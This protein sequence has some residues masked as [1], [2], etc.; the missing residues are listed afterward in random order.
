MTTLNLQVDA[1]ADDAAERDDGTAFNSTNGSENIRANA[2]DS[3]RRNGG[4][5]YHSVTIGNG[6]PIDT[7]TTTLNVPSKNPDDM[8]GDI[9]MND[10]DDAANFS[11]EADVTSRTKTDTAAESW[12]QDNAG[13]GDEVS[14]DFKAHLQEVVDRGGWVSGQAV[15]VLIF[16]KA[17][18]D[19]TFTYNTADGAG[20]APKLD[21][22]FTAA[23]AGAA[24]PFY[25]RLARGPRA[26][27]L[28]R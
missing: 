12:D 24:P 28:R 1:G 23:A 10:V 8:A 19:K 9:S 2:T 14:P 26:A 11:D 18:V 21:I 7:C 17:S 3:T 4:M 22:T 15:C 5:R 16:G 6:D 13:T 27:M 25:N 20:S